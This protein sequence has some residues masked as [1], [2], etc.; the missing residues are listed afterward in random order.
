[1]PILCNER[2]RG[3]NLCKFAADEFETF[4]VC[5]Q[6]VVLLQN[7]CEWTGESS[8]ILP[9][10]LARKPEGSEARWTKGWDV[11][12]RELCME[13]FGFGNIGEVHGLE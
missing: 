10:L 13:V 8:A 2:P 5:L 11:K 7:I 6:L 1:M 9:V 12:I 3:L 4:E